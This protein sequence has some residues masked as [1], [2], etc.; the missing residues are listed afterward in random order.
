MNSVLDVSADDW[1]REI[2]QSDTLVVFD[3]W[4]EQ[5]PWCKRLDPIYR[6]VS[7]EYGERVKFSRLNV[8]QSHENQHVAARYG[9]MGTPTL[10]FFCSG[11]P[12]EA[13]SG[14]LPKDR[15][16]QLVDDVN[17]KRKECIDKSTALR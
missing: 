8:L 5:C 13:V 15:L 2:L 17:S 6:E 3:F 12:I 9:V 10:V 1:E 16:K 7:E 14:F 4:H 11:R